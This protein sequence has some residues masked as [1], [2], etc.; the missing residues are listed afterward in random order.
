[1]TS[2]SASSR[3]RTNWSWMTSTF[4]MDISDLTGVKELGLEPLSAPSDGR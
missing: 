3:I 2:S 4:D 1:M